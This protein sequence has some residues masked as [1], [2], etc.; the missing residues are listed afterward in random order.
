M[1]AQSILTSKKLVQKAIF[2]GAHWLGVDDMGRFKLPNHAMAPDFQ[3]HIEHFLWIARQTERFAPYLAQKLAV[4]SEGVV[5]P[6]TRPDERAY[7]FLA[8]LL[9]GDPEFARRGKLRLFEVA[10]S[11]AEREKGDWC[12]THCWCDAFPFARWLIFYDWIRDSDVFSPA[13]HAFLA[14][15]FLYYLWAHPFQRLKA[16]AIEGTPCN[17]QNGAMGFAC[18]LGGYLFG[19]K[20]G[21]HARAR[22]LLALGLPHLRRFLTAFPRG[23][24]SFEGSTYMSDV[25]A[26]V[27]PLGLELMEAVTGEDLLDHRENAGC[28]SPREVLCAIMRLAAPSGLLLPWDHYGYSRA[29]STTAAAYLAYRTGD[30]RPLRFL[31]GLG[32]LEEPAHVGWGFDKTLWTLFWML[33]ADDDG[34]LDEW[35][36]NW[37]EPRLGAAAAGPARRLFVFQMWDRSHWPPMRAHFNPNSVVMEYDGA[38][39]LL[40]GA[41]VESAKAALFAGPQYRCFRRDINCE[42]NLGGGTVGS[43]NTIFFDDEDHYASPVATEGKLVFSHDEPEASLFESDVTECF[44]FRYDVTVVRRATLALGDD[45]VFIRDRVTSRMPHKVTWRAHVREGE[46]LAR[47]GYFRVNTPD[48]VRL[49]ICVPDGEKMEVRHFAGASSSELEG[50]CHEISRHA[51]GNDL[52]F[53]T[54]LVPTAGLRPWIALNDEW[55]WRVAENEKEIETWLNRWPGGEPL[56]FAKASW[57]YTTRH[58][59]PG[60]G[61]YRRS[62]MLNPPLPVSVWLRLPRLWRS[63]RIRVNDAEFRIEKQREQTPLL[64]CLISI[65]KALRAGANR[66]ELIVPS[67]LETALRGGIA[68]LTPAPRLPESGII[69]KSANVFELHHHGRMDTIEWGENQCVIQ[70]ADGKIISI[71]L[72]GAPHFSRASAETPASPAAAVSFEAPR[73]LPRETLL[74]GI[75][76]CDWRVALDALEAAENTTD[77]EILE[78]VWQ[79]LQRESLEHET[80]PARRADDVCWYRLKAA[81][82]R[83]LGAA[84]FEPATD[85]LGK[86]LLGPDMYPARV[87]CAWALGQIGTPGALRFL[88]AVSKDDEWNTM[89][90]ASKKAWT[91]VDRGG[92]GHSPG[93]RRSLRVGTAAAGAF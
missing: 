18:A 88:Q 82:A 16:R 33:R 59:E 87:A 1:Q 53:Y 31:E 38:P 58:H 83:V 11:V 8:F 90:E 75:R 64:S 76:S 60:I 45:L 91:C 30:H 68:L 42:T 3:R 48:Q 57:F 37:A 43:H 39:L 34:N 55:E 21:D 81:A 71:P 28:A 5:R 2:G 10:E 89:I 93:D 66:I 49:E 52:T 92:D 79:L 77:P 78:V 7:C 63:S 86:I 25:N 12:Q 26:L 20:H 19:I 84:R 54:L 61:V 15:R 17:N 23:G 14:E 56:S 44:R 29:N 67:T 36:F 73:S 70:R 74:S 6:M 80:L 13:D 22:S 50:S 24:Y 72:S 85:L 9:T 4:V 41:C 51:R 62:F 65:G 32:A 27:I 69:R 47:D 46:T 40:D 35:T